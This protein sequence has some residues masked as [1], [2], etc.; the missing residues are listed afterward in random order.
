LKPFKERKALDLKRKRKSYTGYLN[1]LMYPFDQNIS[2]LFEYLTEKDF[3]L[4]HD[5]G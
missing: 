4:L 5:L 1:V 2:L 3:V